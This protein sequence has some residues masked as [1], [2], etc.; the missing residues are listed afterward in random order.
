MLVSDLQDAVLPARASDWVHQLLQ[1]NGADVKFIK[2]PGGH[3]VGGPDILAS[4]AKFIAAS[5]PS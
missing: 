5:L 1:A 4:I 2:H 3:E